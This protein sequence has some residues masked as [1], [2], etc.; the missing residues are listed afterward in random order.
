M[1]HGIYVKSRPKGKWYLVSVT[2]SAE[3]AVSN[4]NAIIDEAKLKENINVQAKIQSFES[5]FYF[6]EILS[7]VKE[8]E[9]LYN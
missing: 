4:M 8:Q 7:E 1:F 3:V 5:S 9:L 6:P 2:M